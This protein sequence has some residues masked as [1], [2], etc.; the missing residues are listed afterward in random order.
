MSSMLSLIGGPGIRGVAV[1][2]VLFDKRHQTLVMRQ[3]LLSLR[4]IT[5]DGGAYLHLWTMVPV[6]I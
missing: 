2:Q 3:V 6:L 1:R 4:Q 5:V